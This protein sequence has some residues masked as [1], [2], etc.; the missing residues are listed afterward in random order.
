MRIYM[1]CC[2]LGRPFDDL[3]HDRIYLE[4]E[5]VLSIISRCEKGEWMLIA[6]GALDFE[7]SRITDKDLMEQIL[8]I[9]SVAKERVKI[10]PDAERRAAILQSQGLR[11]FDSLHVALAEECN[12]DIF[13]TTDAR[14]LKVASREGFN[15]RVENPATWLMEV[16]A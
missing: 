16:I 14:L 15:V 7:L 8:A 4:A 10:S 12:A 13:L 5:A 9:Y 11:P 1:D 6:S 3:S 2:C